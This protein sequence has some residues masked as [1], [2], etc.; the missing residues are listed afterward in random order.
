M[1]D[2]EEDQF[3]SSYR[4]LSLEIA[5]YFENRKAVTHDF[6]ACLTRRLRK[7]LRFLNKAND[8]PPFDMDCTYNS[9]FTEL[10]YPTSNNPLKVLSDGLCVMNHF[11]SGQWE[12]EPFLACVSSRN[13]SD[14]C[15]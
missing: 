13:C 7:S 3:W 10:I 14:Y 5:K 8:N 12:H 11:V 9:C 15:L 2:E 4:V 6:Q 1:P